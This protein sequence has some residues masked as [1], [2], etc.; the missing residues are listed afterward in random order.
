MRV[1]A[2][3]FGPPRAPEIGRVARA[4][5][6]GEAGVLRA[7][8]LAAEHARGIAGTLADRD[9]GATESDADGNV[10]FDW[11]QAWT[12]SSTSV[13]PECGRG[14]TISCPRCGPS[15]RE[16]EVDRVVAA[17]DHVGRER[18]GVGRP[19]LLGNVGPILGKRR[20]GRVERFL[21]EA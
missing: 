10:P 18:R 13:R 8:R 12:G 3:Q 2:S 21:A 9:Q 5:G 17:G 16:F 19:V 1:D 15:R 11:W 6:A 4:G 20:V 7:A 14:G